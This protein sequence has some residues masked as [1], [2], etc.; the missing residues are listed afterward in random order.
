MSAFTEEEARNKTC[1]MMTYCANESGVIN[2]KSSAIYYPNSCAASSC[3]AWRWQSSL[4]VY[5]PDMTPG[6]GQTIKKELGYCGLA[7][8]L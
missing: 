7:W 8:R 1:P 3:M 4:T 5:N 6:A 2:D